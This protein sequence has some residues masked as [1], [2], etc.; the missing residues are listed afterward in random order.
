MATPLPPSSWTLPRPALR[1]RLDAALTHRLTVLS[2]APGYGKTTLVA[3]WVED[4]RGVMVTLTPRHTDAGQLA[5]GILSALRLRVPEVP[6]QVE[7]LGRA[8]LGPSA[9]D[10]GS[11]RPAA[12]ASTIAEEL[13]GILRRH[14]VVA[15]D[16]LE[17]IVGSSDA[18]RLVEALVRAAPPR[19]HLLLTC[20]GPLPFPVERLR[21]QREVLE[22]DATHLALTEEEVR[23]WCQDRLGADGADLAPALRTTTGGWPALVHSR[24][25]ELVG[26]PAADRARAAARPGPRT[27]LQELL[28]SELDV[29]PPGDLALLQAMTVVPVVDDALAGRLADHPESLGQLGSR[30]LFLDAVPRG[31]RL[32]AA[33]RSAIEAHAP[34][35][36]EARRTATA[37]GVAHHLATGAVDLALETARLSGDHALVVELLVTHG[38]ALDEDPTVVLE[39][40]D[41]LPEPDRSAP[42]V[43]A[44]HGIARHNRGDW[45][46]AYALLSTAAEGAAFDATVAWRLGFT[47]HLRGELDRALAVY[48]RGSSHGHP[49]ADAVMC[50]AM[51]AAALWLRGDRDGCARLA[52]EA[53]QRAVTI[54]DPRAL[55]ASH[56]VTAM[57]AAMDGDRR[58]N[59]AHYLRALEFAEAAGDSIQQIRI[60]SNRASHHQEEGAYDE[61]LAELAVAERL[62]ETTGFGWF[63]ALALSNRAEVLLALGR[64]EEAAA[65]A[66]AAVAQWERLGSMLRIYPLTHL[67]HVQRLR[68]D[69]ESACATLTEVL[70]AAERAGEAQGWVPAAAALAELL[71]LDD[72]GRAR[73]LAEQA[74][75]RATGMTTV[76]ALL[77][78]ATVEL[79]VGDSAAADTLLIEAEAA[80]EERRDMPGLARAVELRAVATGDLTM[81]EEAVRRWTVLGDPVGR[82]SAE[83]R[84][85]ELGDRASAADIAGRVEGAMR[86]IGCRSLDDRIA[87]AVSRAGGTGGGVAVQTLGAFRVRRDGE[88][89]SRS[90]WQSRKARDL[91]KILLA[92]RGRPVPRERL[93]EWL[94]PDNAEGPAARKRLN[95][96][97]S[98]LRGVLDPDRAHPA[99]HLVVAA[100]GALRVDLASLEVDVESFLASA[101]DGA[102]LYR[103]GRQ[104]EAIA[105]WEAAEAMYVGDFLAEEAYADWPVSLR[106]EARLAYGEVVGQLARAEAERGEHDAAARYLLR[107]LERDPYDEPAHMALITALAAVGRHGDARRRY[108]LYCARMRELGV[109][110]AA[111]PH[112]TPP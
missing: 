110:P 62:A 20:R 56:T 91:L 13:G 55:A 89:V 27:S 64:L 35:Q 10:A 80:A 107:L 1:Q 82:A 31:W 28:V 106:E 93:V 76:M 21:R 45:E 3:G 99:D 34:P 39:A 102:R 108:L 6:G 4:V 81:A 22:L 53:M 68:G 85:A 51:A 111:F 11:A 65:D 5:A 18:M 78:Q 94:W 67:A 2:A 73:T 43:T 72:P 60:R 41:A 44:L 8:P 24:L 25:D 90:Q 92:H 66:T 109:E 104:A 84:L 26:L 57:L 103:A 86:T 75:G 79:A 61:A 7:L 47:D 9:Q 50:G 88:V 70:D 19:L 29:L 74:R 63:L 100:D 46:A 97:V 48:E 23:A 12:L 49:V 83:L 71:V 69:A 16:G 105:R 14:L 33:A 15:V 98:T 101:A 95:V 59:D 77:A 40:I 17:A 96:Q 87:A 32:S 52:D 30:G 37:A 36:D 112:D 38:R 42:A 54:G 58:A